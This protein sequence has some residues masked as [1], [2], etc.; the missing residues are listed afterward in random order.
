MFTVLARLNHTFQQTSATLRAP[1]LEASG[2]ATLPMEALGLG[3]CCLA[4]FLYASRFLCAAVFIC[5]AQT[6]TAELFKFAYDSIGSD[7]T[8]AAG[9]SLAVGALLILASI[10]TPR[11][12]A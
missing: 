10:F 8:V 11:R 3:F 4:A 5:S 12:T 9:I 1:S 6:H 7:L 2:S